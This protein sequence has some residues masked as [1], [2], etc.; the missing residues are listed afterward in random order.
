MLSVSL[1]CRFFGRFVAIL[2]RKSRCL[3]ARVE[4]ETVLIR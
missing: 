1:L 2:Q 3:A 4:S